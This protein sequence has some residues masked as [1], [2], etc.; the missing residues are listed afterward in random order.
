MEVAINQQKHI[1]P[2][3]CTIQVLINDVLHQQLR[4]I[5]IAIDNVVVP[6]SKW[7]GHYLKSG[8]QIVIIKATQGG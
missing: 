5:A 4:G 1:V 6:K 8:D 3:N 7:D 2:E